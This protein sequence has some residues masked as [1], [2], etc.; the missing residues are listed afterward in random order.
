MPSDV[1]ERLD[2]L[3]ARHHINGV[4]ISTEPL[5]HRAYLAYALERGLNVLVDKPLTTRSAA[6]H[7][8][9]QARGIWEDY[10]EILDLYRQLQER[11]T[12][13]LM[14][15]SHRRYHPGFQ[16]VLELITEIRD[17]FR[18]PVTSIAS[19]HCDGQWRL[20]AEIVT[21]DYHPYNRGYGKVSHSGYHTL[22]MVACF[23]RAGYVPGKEP[24]ALS[25]TTSFLLP[26]GFIEQMHREDYLRY[27]GSAYD[28]LCPYS[29]AD[30]RGQVVRFG[31]IDAT[32]LLEYSRGGIPIGSATISLLHNGFSRRSWVRPGRDLYKGNGRVRHERHRI[33]SGPF[34]TVY[35]ESYQ[36]NDRHDGSSDADYE[37][38]GNNHFD[39]AVY[40]N[41][42]MTGD[43]EPQCVF[44]FTDLPGA[45]GFDATRLQNEQVKEAAL[46]EFLRF[47]RGQLPLEQLR[48]NI[49]NHDLT[50]RIM[51]AIY[52]A[53]VLRR[54]G[55]AG[56]VK[57]DL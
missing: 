50:V 35:I 19:E 25:V 30:L 1:R 7:D 37:R 26:E 49:E 54:L 55:G 33:I 22:D 31:E 34:Q 57:K 48:S 13:C 42:A 23:L 32:A 56:W 21:Q 12:T 10:R 44:R 6:A 9:G 28:E 17:R 18:C 40:R 46:L 52:E 38:G 41:C 45:E 15:N 51:S 39:I 3:V 47:I 53:H 36:A 14:V 8:L 24:D 11:R 27:F 29:D 43:P 2:G 16:A 5:A 4:I 20:P